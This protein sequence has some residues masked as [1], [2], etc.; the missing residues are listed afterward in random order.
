MFRV[1]S[2]QELSPNVVRMEI[3]APRVAKAYQA[4]QF[5][6]VRVDER[7]ERIPLTIAD[8]DPGKIPLR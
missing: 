8:A 6:I 1:I 4:G 3:N 5:A 7:G 2:R